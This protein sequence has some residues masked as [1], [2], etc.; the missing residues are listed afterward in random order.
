MVKS[1]PTRKR[2]LRV[3][4]APLTTDNLGTKKELKM[5]NL[6]KFAKAIVSRSAPMH[7]TF[8]DQ[9][10]EK[11]IQINQAD[12]QAA[13]QAT[14]QAV[15]LLGELEERLLLPTD[16]EIIAIGHAYVIADSM[17]NLDWVDR[18]AAAQRLYNE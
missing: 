16:K 18:L 4:F 12:E 13:K 8:V 1:C 10:L 2:S 11:H 6:T 7:K 5:L 3:R 9:T 15:Q 14:Q 17:Q